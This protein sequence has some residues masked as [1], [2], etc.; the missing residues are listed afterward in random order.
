EQERPKAAAAGRRQADRE[1]EEALAGRPPRRGLDDLDVAGL[2]DE[3]AGLV[4]LRVLVVDDVVDA[5]QGEGGVDGEARHL[6][7]QKR[8]L[9][10]GG[11]HRAL[12]AE[13][14]PDLVS[15]SA[16]SSS[17]PETVTR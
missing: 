8:A 16:T 1:G 15:D 10:R 5:G 12:A 6:A 9:A 7:L 17:A 4:G 13:E 11:D 2:A 14:E 3:D